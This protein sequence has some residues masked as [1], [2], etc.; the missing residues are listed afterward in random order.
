MLKGSKADVLKEGIAWSNLS[1]DAGHLGPQVARISSAKP[2]PGTAPWLTGKPAGHNVDTAAPG[3][4]VERAHVL[5]DRERRQKS[6]EL[7]GLEHL[8]AVGVDLDGSDAL[9]PQQQTAKDAAS[10]AG[11]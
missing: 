6:L 9:M 4:A 5:E 10:D 2:L 7:P 3:S 11:E 8:A 1:D